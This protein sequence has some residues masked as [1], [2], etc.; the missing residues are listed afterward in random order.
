MLEEDEPLPSRLAQFQE[1]ARQSMQWIWGLVLG[2]AATGA[3]ALY[4]EYVVPWETQLERAGF[5]GS[6]LLSLLIVQGAMWKGWQ[7]RITL[8]EL[9][10]M[11]T[12]AGLGAMFC[13][14]RIRR[15]T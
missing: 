12:L 6:N 13:R 4:A 14:R 5:G 9:L 15:V 2:L 11:V 10:S 3:Y 8:L 7:S 1:R